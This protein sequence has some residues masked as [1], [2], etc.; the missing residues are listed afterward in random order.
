MN[1]PDGLDQQL[2]F[3]PSHSHLILHTMCDLL[4]WNGLS[5]ESNAVSYDARAAL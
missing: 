1:L 4:G 2:P 3:W 5:L